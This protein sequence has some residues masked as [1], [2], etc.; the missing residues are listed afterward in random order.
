[1]AGV[2]L[3]SAS[4]TDVHVIALIDVNA[5]GQMQQPGTDVFG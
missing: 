1:M 4:T 2:H 3:E 5:G